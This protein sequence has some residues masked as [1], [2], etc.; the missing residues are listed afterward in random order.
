M[1]TLDVFA[2]LSTTHV[3]VVAGYEVGVGRT[4]PTI[5]AFVGLISVIAGGLAVSARTRRAGT[6]RSRSVTAL[7]LGAIAV[8]VGGIHG[9]DAAGGFGTGNGLAGAI[10]AVVLGLGGVVLGGLSL[11]RAHRFG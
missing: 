3:S 7:A 8:V 10:A 6:R 9:A 2:A 11:V 5:A 1:S 4:V